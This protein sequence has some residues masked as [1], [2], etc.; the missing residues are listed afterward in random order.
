LLLIALL[1]AGG[2]R[3]EGAIHTRAGQVLTWGTAL[4]EWVLSPLKSHMLRAGPF[5]EGACLTDLDRD[6]R[7][8]FV[9]VR[10]ARLGTLLWM[11]LGTGVEETIDREV[12][13]SDCVEADLFGRRG[14]LMIHRGA[15]VR[16]YERT[17]AGRWISRDIYSIY[18]PS[19]QR[20]L[21]LADVD[22]DG[23]IDIFCGNYWIRSPARFEES[24]RLFAIHTW[25]EDP[26]SASVRIAVLSPRRIAV[27]QARLNPARFAVFDAPADATQPWKATPVPHMLGRIHVLAVLDGKMIAG[28][29]GGLIVDRIR[30]SEA[31]VSGVVAADRDK[32]FVV[33]P[34]GARIIAQPPARR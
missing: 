8:E 7:E 28:G 16:F 24:W 30:V 27:A 29:D 31:P 19:Y 23:H 2:E 13:M 12:E 21:A 22:G 33:G 3:F 26:D 11:V 20:G 6:G 34:A 4:H 1:A 15:Q 25:F 5:G 14:V 17:G 10:G 32:L 9:S 18:T